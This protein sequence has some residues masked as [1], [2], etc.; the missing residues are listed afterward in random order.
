MDGFS[1]K[2]PLLKGHFAKGSEAARRRGDTF[3][4][5][6]KDYMAA[7]SLQ[8]VTDDELIRIFKPDYDRASTPFE[9]AKLKTS[10]Q[11]CMSSMR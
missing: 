4:Q 9:L 3:A 6:P 1:Y 2:T 5:I 11:E 10:F 7:E 8:L